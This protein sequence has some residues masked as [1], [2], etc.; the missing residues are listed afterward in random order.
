MMLDQAKHILMI[1]KSQSHVSFEISRSAANLKVR[2][3]YHLDWKMRQWKK[4]NSA[5]LF[6]AFEIM[7]DIPIIISQ[8]IKIFIT[9][10]RGFLL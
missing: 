2:F 7:M 4:W 1:Q 8:L 9:F 10:R 3:S 6:L 5:A